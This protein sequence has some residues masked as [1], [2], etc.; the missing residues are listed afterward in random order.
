MPSGFPREWTVR[1]FRPLSNSVTCFPC[2]ELRLGREKGR[3]REKVTDSSLLPAQVEAFCR[4]GSM[5]LSFLEVLQ[6]VT[7]RK[8]SGHSAYCI[9]SIQACR[10]ATVTEQCGC[11][12]VHACVCTRVRARVI[13]RWKE[14]GTLVFSISSEVL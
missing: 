1:E 4:A 9:N 3:E 11:M 6:C 7:I 10:M 12:C 14:I 8:C 5:E 2:V 13:R